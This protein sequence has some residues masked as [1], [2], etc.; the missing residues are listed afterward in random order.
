MG[1]RRPGARPDLPSVFASEGHTLQVFPTSYPVEHSLWPI[2][3]K[4][5][6]KAACSV[7]GPCVR[8]RDA[9]LLD[10]TS[11]TRQPVQVPR[12]YVHIR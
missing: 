10:G 7:E 5:Q 9:S 1:V 8:A 6:Y 4:M 3:K 12:G 2:E 11:V